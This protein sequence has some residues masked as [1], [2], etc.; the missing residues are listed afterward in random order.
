MEVSE[1]ESRRSIMAHLI[2]SPLPHRRPFLPGSSTDSAP[3]QLLLF[4]FLPSPSLFFLSNSI[5]SLSSLFLHIL[6]IFMSWQQYV[7][8][9]LLGSGTISQA[10]ILGQKD[11]AA[12]ATSPGFT[13]RSREK[14]S[15]SLL[16][17]SSLL[18]H[19][20]SPP[21]SQITIPPSS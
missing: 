21:I 3:F 7:D 5:P 1:R 13:V 9:Q 16:I 20:L 17:P 6:S 12:W 8:E 2:P 19:I 18:T 15:G 4:H 10:A 14:D 11:M